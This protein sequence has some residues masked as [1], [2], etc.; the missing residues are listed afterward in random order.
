MLRCIGEYE[1]ENYFI[2]EIFGELFNFIVLN[3]KDKIL[4]GGMK[5]G[6][7]FLFSYRWFERWF[8]FGWNVYVDVRD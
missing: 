3:L 4:I 6:K 1:G 7:W 2:K 8:Y 5:V